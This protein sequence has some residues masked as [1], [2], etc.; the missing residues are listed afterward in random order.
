MIVMEAGIGGRL[1]QLIPVAGYS[2][3]IAT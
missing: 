2:Q 1:Q 3:S